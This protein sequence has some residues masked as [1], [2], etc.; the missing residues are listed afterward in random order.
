[1]LELPLFPLQ[2]AFGEAQRQVAAKYGVALL[3]K[4]CFAA[5]LGTEGATHDGLHLSQ[6]GHDAMAKVIASVIQVK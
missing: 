1:M 5:V 3:P 2:N 4:R 6:V